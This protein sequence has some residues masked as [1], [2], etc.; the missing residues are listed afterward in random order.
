MNRYIQAFDT[1]VRSKAT[2]AKRGNGAFIHSCH[3]HCE[4]QD[5]AW[6]T[7][8][9]NNVTMQ[10]AFSAWWRSSDDPS[11][12]HSYDTCTYHVDKEPH[13]CNPTCPKAAATVLERVAAFMRLMMM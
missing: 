3:T 7:F 13:Q 2:Y 12:L 6:N 5:T 10:Q 9:V 11:S 4:A 1:A 8:K